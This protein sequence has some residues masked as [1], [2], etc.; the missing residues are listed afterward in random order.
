MKKFLILTSCVALAALTVV[1]ADDNKKK[2]GQGG[3]GGGGG[4][5][6]S[7]GQQQ[8]VV[9]GQGHP[10]VGQHLNQTGPIVHSNKL[11]TFK[12]TNH[13]NKTATFNKNVNVNK[14]LTVNKNVT[15]NKNVTFNKT[16]FKGQ[17]FNLGNKWN[18]KITPVKFQGNYHIPGSQN[19]HGP[20]Y[21][22]FQN[23]HP[24]WHDHIWWSNHYS[25]HIV[26]VFGSPYYWD[27]G[28]YYPAWGYQP[29]AYYAY[30]G[31]IY[32]GE[33]QTDPG[34]VVANVQTALQQ[35]GYYQGDVD[36]ILGPQT[37]GALADY[38]Q[39]QG[40]EATGAVDEPTLE[41]LGLA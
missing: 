19:W 25:N 8:R 33:A 5:G 40:L 2:K 23:Y 36:G 1:H 4:G 27:S 20:K 24:M 3:G 32:V 13:V 10:N 38:Q 16:T 29:A 34:Q 37:R 6:G 12:N 17:H 14:N 11:T 31:P 9:K 22:V 28:Y 7:Q 21:V 39:A 35:Q 15:L 30:D 26:F 18:S 41:A